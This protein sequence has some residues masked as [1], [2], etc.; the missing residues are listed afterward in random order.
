MIYSEITVD[1][2]EER[3]KVDECERQENDSIAQLPITIVADRR[4][5]D[6]T[7]TTVFV[8]AGNAAGELLVIRRAKQ[9]GYGLLGLPG[10]YQK[11][12]ETRQQA[13]VRELMEETKNPW[14]LFLK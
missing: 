4:V 12:G 6:N 8:L 10:G 5:Y 7:S 1:R 14:M 9:P 2:A 13:G 3:G 11:R